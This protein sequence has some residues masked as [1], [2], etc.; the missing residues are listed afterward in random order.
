MCRASIVGQG[1]TTATIL[2]IIDSRCHL[3][4]AQYIHHDK[5]IMLFG[6]FGGRRNKSKGWSDCEKALRMLPNEIKRDVTVHIFGEVG[7]DYDIDG[8]PIHFVG[9]QSNPDVLNNVYNSADLF[10]FPSVE[11]TQGMTKIEALLCGLPV[12]TFDRTACAEGGVHGQTGWVAADGDLK[13]DEL[14][15]LRA[16]I[17]QL[18]KVS[19]SSQRT[20]EQVQR[21]YQGIP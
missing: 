13:K 15:A 4:S 20:V 1:C 12:I 5:M 3:D 11:E 9:T 18:A 8:L 14:I 17:A 10:L 16:K 6:A 2:N 19:F 7:D 21:I